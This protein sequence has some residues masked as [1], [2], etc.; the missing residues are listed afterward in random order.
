M[1]VRRLQRAGPGV[2]A[3]GRYPSD[4][5]M[6]VKFIFRSNINYPFI[7]LSVFF[8]NYVRIGN[9]G[10]SK[11]DIIFNQKIALVKPEALIIN[12]FL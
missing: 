2:S 8:I 10:G 12:I 5:L 3:R 4:L 6:K 9:R 7:K 1:M 11:T